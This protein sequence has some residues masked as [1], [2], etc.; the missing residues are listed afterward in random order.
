[1]WNNKARKWTAILTAVMMLF[2][3]VCVSAES[4]AQ[5]DGGEKFEGEWALAGCLATINYEEEGYR[6]FIEADNQEGGGTEWEY[7]CYYMKDS[8]SLLSINSSRTDF[9]YDADTGD[10][11]YAPS[12]YSGLD[13]ENM[14]SGFTID[15]NGFL[16]WKDAHDN[17]GADLQF[18]NIGG[19]S[20]LW[21]NEAEETEAEFL[22]NGLDQETFNYT[23]FIMRGKSTADQYATYLMNGEYDPATGKLTAYGTCT[24]F[25]KNASGEYESSE[26]GE[27]YEAIFSRTENGNVLYETDNGIEL[28]YDILGSNG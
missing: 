18:M 20:G 8:D 27:N 12:A 4:A 15:E 21:K 9:T 13:D 19:F 3:V 24:L 17:A 7:A 23:V 28:E 5:S 10:K 11:V 26:D 22:W 2:A 1:M 6:V 16:L 14:S 25:T